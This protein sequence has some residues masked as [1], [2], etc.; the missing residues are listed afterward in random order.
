MFYLNIQWILI[1]L[2]A[3]FKILELPI[4]SEMHAKSPKQ[5]C[6]LKTSGFHNYS[7][8]IVISKWESYSRKS[9]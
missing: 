5:L 4:I 3:F 6:V 1:S 2:R 9:I 8:I 7:L